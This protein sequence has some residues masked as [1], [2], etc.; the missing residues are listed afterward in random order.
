MGLVFL[1]GSIDFLQKTLFCEATITW[2]RNDCN[3]GLF[4]IVV[5][6]AIG[7]GCLEDFNKN[8][9]QVSHFWCL[10]SYES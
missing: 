7:K 9:C 6:Q 10:N 3:R 1:H 4:S 8:C 5:N 2:R